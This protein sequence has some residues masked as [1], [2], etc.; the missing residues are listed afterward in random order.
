[1]SPLTANLLLVLA[2]GVFLVVLALSLIWQLGAWNTQSVHTLF[3][4]E[5]LPIGGL[6]DEIA[7]TG[8]DDEA[9]FHLEFNDGATF[10]VFGGPVCEPCA[11]L[12]ENAVQHPVIRHLRLVYLFTPTR[13]SPEERA[14]VEA[15]GQEETMDI[16]A[17]SALAKWEVYHFEDEALVRGRW[18]APVSPYF[19]LIDSKGVVLSKGV[20]SLPEHL[21]SLVSIPPAVLRN[22][23]DRR[24]TIPLEALDLAASGTE[25]PSDL[26]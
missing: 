2:I 16:V 24:G 7:A 5:G 6:A 23:A 22:S 17:P 19:H 11:R 4:D 3:E 26:A 13:L 8:V 18:N 9:E 14:A 20:A 25:R 10:L 21:D 12:L 15:S 1:M